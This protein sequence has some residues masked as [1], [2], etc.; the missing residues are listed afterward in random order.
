MLRL[1]GVIIVVLLLIGPLM[2]QIG[3][4]DHGGLI[5]EFVDIETKLFV[6]LVAAIRGLWAR[7]RG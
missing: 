5:R 7:A 3:M 6:D 1:I 2:V 4:L